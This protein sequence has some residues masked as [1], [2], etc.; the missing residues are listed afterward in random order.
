[1]RAPIRLL[2]IAD[3]CAEPGLKVLDER[4]SNLRHELDADIVIANGE[5]AL[6]G[7]SMNPATYRRLRDAGVDVI[8]GGNHT[9]DRFQIHGLLKSE[10]AL[11][12]PLNYPSGCSGQGWTTHLLPGRAPIVVMNVQ[13]RVFM[14]PID[15]PFRS[16]ER[17]LE[18]IEREVAGR[19]KAPVIFVDM[20]AEASAEKAAMAH[21]LDGRVSALVGTHTHVQTADERI[22]PKG[23]AFLTDAGM[24]GCHDSVIGLKA[25]VA[26]RRFLYQTPHRYEPAEGPGVL[27]GVLVEVDEAS[28]QATRIQ[29]IQLPA[30][31]TER[32]PD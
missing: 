16:M 5:N 3:V 26:V 29:R 8:T 10:S 14:Q 1:M 13:G 28:R 6:D 9:W 12:R 20:H 11:L 15:C 22:F 21:F 7:K 30:F 24:T 2:F 27:Q 18:R 23:T 17:E 31:P 25:D 32:K 19:M 4:L